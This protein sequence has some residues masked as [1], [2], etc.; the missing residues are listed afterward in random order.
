MS[1]SATT[2]RATDICQ[3]LI[4]DPAGPDALQG[5]AREVLRFADSL[6]VDGSNDPF[7]ED[8]LQMMISDITE[9]AVA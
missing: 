2:I 9:R 5:L 4:A 6:R 8:C 3:R 1:V 7:Y